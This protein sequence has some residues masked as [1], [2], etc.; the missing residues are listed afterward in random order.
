MKSLIFLK[1]FNNTVDRILHV[2][3]NYTGGVLEMA[4]I[5]DQN[6]SREQIV[7]YLPELIGALKRHS[8]VFRNVRL[9]LIYW[10]ADDDIVCQVLPMSVAQ[11][12]SHYEHYERKCQKKSFEKLAEYLKMF[13]ARAKLQILLTDGGYTAEREEVIAAA[14]RPFLEKKLLEIVI[15][16]D[17]AE[18]RYRFD[19]TV[20]THHG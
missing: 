5:I 17:G 15:A 1:N 10:G 20:G 3:G 12:S 7:E 6:L 19:R 14:M 11:M 18:I 4:V 9:N 16:E 8:P 13:Q 2:P